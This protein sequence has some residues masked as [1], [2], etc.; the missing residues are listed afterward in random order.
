[1]YLPFIQLL[2][3][4][5]FTPDAFMN[6]QIVDMYSKLLRGA[7]YT[8]NDD[9]KYAGVMLLWAAAKIG[10]LPDYS[11]FISILVDLIKA[12]VKY[13]YSV[14]GTL[15]QLA[16]YPETA[17]SMKNNQLIPYFQS[18]LNYPQFADFAKQFLTF[19]KK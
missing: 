10:P 8:N 7:L 15:A 18:L 6:P 1:M 17:D 11:L 4:I 3:S 19:V 12:Q 14:I 13:V 16:R 5:L 9:L 2:A